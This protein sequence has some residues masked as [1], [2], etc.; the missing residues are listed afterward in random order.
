LGNDQSQFYIIAH[1]DEDK[2]WFGGG[3]PIQQI[4][5]EANRIVIVIAKQ[6]NSKRRE[7]MRELTA[8]EIKYLTLALSEKEI[9]TLI[10]QG[11][12]YHQVCP[13]IQVASKL[14]A[15]LSGYRLTLTFKDGRLEW[16]LKQITTKKATKGRKI[17]ID[18]VVYE[19]AEEA[20]KQLNLEDKWTEYKTVDKE[21][22]G[23]GAMNFLKRKM[24]LD[25]QYIDDEEENETNNQG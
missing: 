19:S 15:E 21:N 12:Q 22:L 7:K 25:V 3:W 20:I 2:N 4:D 13:I 9:D 14:K 1:I 11:K 6:K 23:V 8:E 16:K 5:I 24:K 10:E 18:N 17:R